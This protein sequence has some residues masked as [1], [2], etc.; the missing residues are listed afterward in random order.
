MQ[1]SL[2]TA[3]HTVVTNHCPECLIFWRSQDYCTN[4][5]SFNGQWLEGRRN[6]AHRYIWRLHKYSYTNV[7]DLQN[8]HTSQHIFSHVGKTPSEKW[9]LLRSLLL[10]EKQAQWKA[11]DAVPP[12]KSRYGPKN[13]QARSPPGNSEKEEGGWNAIS[14]ALC[15]SSPPKWPPAAFLGCCHT[16]NVVL[17]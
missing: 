11:Y 7:W 17:N 12:Q 13:W 5:I 4:D 10:N 1:S 15:S 16:N 3:I 8:P 2:P 14:K 9:P 6:R